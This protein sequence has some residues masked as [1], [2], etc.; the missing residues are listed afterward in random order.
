MAGT[1][2]N[3][4]AVGNSGG[5]T[6]QDRELAAHV[7]SLALSEIQKVLMLGRVDLY[8]AV[9][10]KL[11]GS[12]LPKLNEHAGEGGGPIEQ[13]IIYSP[14]RNERMEAPSRQTDR[15]STHTATAGRL[16][17]CMVEPGAEE[18]LTLARHGCSTTMSTRSTAP[19]SSVNTPMT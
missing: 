1:N 9:L 5:K 6:L 7:R 12:V 3:K 13:R 4:N 18:R 8:R 15:S 2:G 14:Q 11:A 10:I 17:F 19:W 16:K